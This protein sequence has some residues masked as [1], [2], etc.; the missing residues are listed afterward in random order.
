MNPLNQL[1]KEGYRR[2]KP[3]KAAKKTVQAVSEEDIACYIEG[4]FGKKEQDVFMEKVIGGDEEENL[5][6]LLL[7]SK[8]PDMA[9][10][11][12]PIELV[13]KVK[14]LVTSSC[15]EEMLS[16]VIEFKENFAQVV[17]TTGE[18]IACAGRGELLPAGV[19]RDKEEKTEHHVIELSKLIGTFIVSVKI[20]KI[21]KDF[22]DL[23][24]YIKDRRKNTPVSGE[25]IS[26]IHQDRELRSCLTERGKVEYDNLKVRDYQLNLVRKGEPRCIAALSLRSLEG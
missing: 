19:F 8:L 26:L 14:Q 9:D 3:K 11:D 6:N 13:D 16:A 12:V 4:L 17:K 5:R 24:V 1:I 20:T 7:T 2:F 25:R 22:I 15:L 23:V 18:I 10:A 21:A